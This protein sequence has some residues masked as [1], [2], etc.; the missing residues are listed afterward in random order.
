MCVEGIFLWFES[1]FLVLP[2]VDSN[3]EKEKL[4]WLLLEDEGSTFGWSEWEKG[5]RRGLFFFC[6]SIGVE[7]ARNRDVGCGENM[8]NG[9]GI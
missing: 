9:V 5:R 4:I 2:Q 1:S 3:N 8:C 7:V 6:A